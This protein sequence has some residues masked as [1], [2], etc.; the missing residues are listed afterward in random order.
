MNDLTSAPRAPFNFSKAIFLPFKSG[1]GSLNFVFRSAVFYAVL[2]AI[3]YMI[4]LPLTQGHTAEHQKLMENA[5]SLDEITASTTKLFL[6]QIPIYLGFWVIWAI[7]ETALHRRV[8][9]GVDGGLFPWRFGGDELRVMLCQVVNIIVFSVVFFFIFI[10]SVMVFA[11]ITTVAGG[12][13]AAILFPS[14]LLAMLVGLFVASIIAIRL[15]GASAAS[16]DEKQIAF[17]A[18]W[19]SAKGRF[20]PSFGAY[21]LL[22]IVG[23]LI[24]LLAAGLIMFMFYGDAMTEM[25]TQTMNGNAEAAT[26]FTNQITGTAES[27]LKYAVFT[28]PISFIGCI[29]WLC[30]AGMSSHLI[31]LGKIDK[32]INDAN[33]FD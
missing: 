15:A 19:Q 24:Y 23:G 9:R 16:V 22:W 32:G 27:T 8:Q 18:A 12:N 30:I 29:I 14:T 3:L 26:Q 2:V 20:W 28:F 13:K 5:A 1:T 6:L 33:I 25:F 31:N 10:V 17:G 7:V 21:S 4:T 11:V